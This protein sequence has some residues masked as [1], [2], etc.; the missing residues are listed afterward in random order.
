L[1]VAAARARGAAGDGG[2]SLPLEAE[3]TRAHVLQILDELPDRH[4]VVL[5]WKYLDA[6]RV[7]EIAER[8]GDSEQAVESVLYRARRDFRRLF[9]TRRLRGGDVTRAENGALAIP[10]SRSR[11]MTM[12][13]DHERPEESDARQL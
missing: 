11:S 7:R 4:R 13:T 6:L 12:A 8:F 10:N 2:P 3:E 1:T 9:E 5:E